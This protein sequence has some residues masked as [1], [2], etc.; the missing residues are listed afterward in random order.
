MRQSI[1]STFHNLDILYHFLQNETHI[2]NQKI[3]DLDL[4]FL[5]LKNGS[6]LM[7]FMN[8]HFLLKNIWTEVFVTKLRQK[9][10]PAKD[11]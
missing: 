1:N 7:I 5:N 9:Q 6:L 10:V 4:D 3:G 11:F 2:E 8:I